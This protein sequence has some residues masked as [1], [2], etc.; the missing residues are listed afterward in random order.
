[1]SFGVYIHIP[2]CIQRCSYCD[3]ATYV[4]SE[5]LPPSQYV[6]LLNEEIKQHSF[7]QP[8]PLDT[9][10]FGGGTPSLIEASLI[11]SLISALEKRGFVRSPEAEVTIE[12]NPA[13]VDERKLEVYLQH[14]INRFSVG[15]QTFDDQL[16][17][18]V[19][20]EHNAEQTL[21]TLRLLKKYNLNFSFDILFALPSQTKD[22]L[23]RDLEIAV[24]LGAKH[25]SPYCLTVPSGH[26]LSKARPSDEDQVEM[27]N[28]IREKLEDFGYVQYEI[29]N[30]SLPGFESRHNN[31]YWSDDEYWGLGLSAHSYSRESSWGTRFW[32]PSNIGSYQALIQSHSGKIYE[33]PDQSLD[34]SH[35]EILKSNQSLTDLCHTFLRRSLGLSPAVVERKFGARVLRSVETRLTKLRERELLHFDGGHW[36]LTSQGRLMSNLVFEELTFLEPV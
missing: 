24:E 31:L 9:I 6:D 32:N 5:I 26:P 19:K 22:G 15:A 12:I 30:F 29:S 33:R 36:R 4:Q 8:Q 11:V 14:G 18:R 27:F 10:Y 16:L 28:L 21:Q 13:T 7:F 1:M 20:R 23:N 2:Y 17:K 3:F 35:F 25:I 34:A